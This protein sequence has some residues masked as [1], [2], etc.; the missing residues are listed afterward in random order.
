M[1]RPYFINVDVEL[2][3]SDDISSVAIELGDRIGV[4]LNEQVGTAYHLNFECVGYS[5]DG[6]VSNV[7]DTLLKLLEGLSLS[8]KKYISNCDK[9]SIDIGYNSGAEGWLYSKISNDLLIR[10][11][12]LGFE[13]NISLYGIEPTARVLD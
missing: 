13:L 10:V 1:S 4:M 8:S 7:I 3:S 9:K 6:G 2:S 5:G 12:G 11:A